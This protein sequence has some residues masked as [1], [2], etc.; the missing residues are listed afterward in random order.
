MKRTIVLLLMSSIAFYSFAQKGDKKESIFKKENLFTGGDMTF[1]LGNNFTV[2]GASPYFGYS[3]N[4]FVDVAASFGY[5]YTSQRDIQ[6]PGADD[7]VRQ[8][9]ISPGAFARLYPIKWLFAQAQYEHNFIRQKYLP[10]EFSLEPQ[11]TYRVDANSLLL[12]GGIAGGRDIDNNSFYYFSIA[13]DVL[14]NSNSP[15]VDELGR[16]RPILRA[17]YNIALF[18]GGSRR[19]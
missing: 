2:L 5:L 12:G 7:K 15:Y 3:I 14:K 8:T 1:S 9:I 10:G 13:W 17:G 19:R 18:Q 11:G 6:Y 16:N 4:R